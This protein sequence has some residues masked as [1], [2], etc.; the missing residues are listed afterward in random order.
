MCILYRT[1]TNEHFVCPANSK[2]KD[3]DPDNKSL[4]LV[5]HNYKGQIFKPLD[6]DIC[7]LDN[8]KGIASALKFNK[9]CLHKPRQNKIN[10]TE[11]KRTAKRKAEPKAKR[12]VLTNEVQW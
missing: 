12:A 8:G 9:A 5:Y 11:I 10:S 7:E 2:R 6:I 3:V 1:E 4:N